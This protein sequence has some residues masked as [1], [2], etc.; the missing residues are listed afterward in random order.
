VDLLTIELPGELRLRLRGPATHRNLKIQGHS[1]PSAHLNISDPSAIVSYTASDGTTTL[2][3]PGA[4]GPAFFEDTRYRLIIENLANTGVPQLS[5][6]YPGLLTDIDQ[7][8]A[9]HLLTASLN[10]GRSVG[11]SS[12]TIRSG[13]TRV[14]LDVEVFPTKLDY[15]TDFTALLHEVSNVA[16][17]LAL[18]YL[19]A[20]FIRGGTEDATKPAGLEWIVL[21]RNQMDALEQAL[22]YVAEHPHRTLE[23]YSDTLSIHRL[24]RPDPALRRAATR[25]LG[26]GEPTYV[27]GIGLIRQRLPTQPTRESLNTPEHRWLRH[28]LQMVTIR[29][30]SIYS[31]IAAELSAAESAG[32]SARNLKAEEAEVSNMLDRLQH[33]RALAPFAH[34]TGAPPT[35]T[36]SLT[37]INGLGYRESYRALLALR[38][39]L[40]LDGE[41]ID[42]SLK[43]LHVLYETWCFVRLAQLV[44]SLTGAKSTGDII[45]PVVGSGLRVRLK[46][47]QRSE[48]TFDAGHRQLALLYNPT[49]PG[50]TGNQRPDIVLELRDEGWPRIIVVFDAKYRLHSDDD[51][52]NSFGSAG[53]PIDAV[54]ALHR[55]RDAIVVA[56][57]AERGRPTVKGIALFPLPTELAEQFHESKL[58][59]SIELL[60]VGALPFTPNN[61]GLVVN[62]LRKFLDLPSTDIATPGP[63]FLA[64]EHLRGLE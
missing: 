32:R 21:L 31:E 41:Q 45:A 58:F 59:A 56:T 26:T 23:R 7:H 19:R 44:A 13:T 48:I 52:V 27:P 33:L 49:Y 22:R 6:R 4:S 57:G 1:A 11:I 3:E 14:D 37:L 28:Q 34:A 54:N 39:G 43:D 51:Y 36:P 18:E 64:L 9:Q 15:A 24:R 63:P 61:A 17:A 2:W 25:G 47:G 46:A 29:L 12:I 50:L 60:G 20:T 8:P 38:L 40:S 16:R 55:Y 30:A 42:F 5:H 53:P 62:W 10:F 35:G